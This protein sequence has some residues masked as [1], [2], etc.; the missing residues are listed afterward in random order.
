MVAK[1]Y[2]AVRPRTN[3]NHTV[4]KDGCPFLPDDDKRIY[5]GD[6]NSGRDA[7]RVAKNYF[8]RTDSC[9]FC[10]KEHS[11]HKEQPVLIK[12]FI[13]EFISEEIRKESADYK[14]LVCCL[15]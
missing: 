8:I 7:V 11:E 13:M 2:V 15:N 3:E 6:F 14:S 10:S 1:Y 4:H 9:R 5:L 12:Q